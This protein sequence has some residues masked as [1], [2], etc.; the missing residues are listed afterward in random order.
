MAAPTSLAHQVLDLAAKIGPNVPAIA[1]R[2][3][4]SDT[5]VRQIL[6]RSPSHKQ[7][8]EQPNSPVLSPNVA[9]IMALRDDVLAELELRV[10]ELD[11]RNLTDLLKVLLHYETQLSGAMRPILY[12][13]Q[14]QQAV[15]G[16]IVAALDSADDAT[17]LQLAGLADQPKVI[18]ID[19][20]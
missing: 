3:E 2:L 6:A 17:L 18:D 4:I 11:D 20:D 1:K 9:K 14:R 10:A 15:V 13:D 16:Q 19:H 8:G 12:Q 7:A 5:Y